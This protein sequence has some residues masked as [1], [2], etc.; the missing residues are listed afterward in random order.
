VSARVAVVTGASS[1]IGAACVERLLDEGWVVHAWDRRPSERPGVLDALVDVSDPVA[2]SALAAPIASLD[3]LVNAAGISDRAPAAEMHPDQ[4]RRVIDVDLSGT[5]YC[6]Q[7]LYPALRAGRGV[8]VNVASIAG[9]RS[10]AGRVNYCAAKAGV[11][12]LTEVLGLEWAAD[13]VR[14]LAVSP[15]F[16]AT[17]MVRVGIEGGWVSEAAITARTPMGRLATPA[18]IA[19]LIVAMAGDA[20]AYVTG[21][22]IVADGGWLANGGF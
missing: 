21:T 16:V 11:V 10:F 14:V 9:H 8:I 19:A 7:A 17:E 12:A 13:A 22:T 3:L 4:W 5:F 1:G 15:G 18:E 6:C 20:F 2:V